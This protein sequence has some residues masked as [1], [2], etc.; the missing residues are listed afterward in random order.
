MKLTPIFLLVCTL[1]SLGAWAQKES[2]KGTVRDAKGNPL[3]GV[4]VKDAN[5]KAVTLTN[6]TGSYSINAKAND[7][8][9]FSFIGFETKKQLATGNNVNIVF[10]G[11]VHAYER[12]YP[13]YKNRTDKYAPVYITIGDGGNLEGLD[14][15]Y[16]EQP[17]WSAY[18][19]GTQYGHG[20]LSLINKNKLFFF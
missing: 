20:I 14:N 18:R 8:L 16:Y 4:T 17:K 15:K 6:N 9:E 7:V 10:S 3:E 12:T 5:S 1:L 2:I 11:H 13:V 19:N